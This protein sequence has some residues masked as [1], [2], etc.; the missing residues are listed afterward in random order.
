VTAVR[1]L[2]VEREDFLD[3]LE[4]HQDL[5]RD[6]LAMLAQGLIRRVHDV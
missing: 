3:V 6:T 1:G 2:R 4:D 5:A